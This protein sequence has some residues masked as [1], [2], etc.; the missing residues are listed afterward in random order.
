M[1][2]MITA[3]N[4]AAGGAAI[5]DPL[6]QAHIAY[7]ES[8]HDILLFSGPTKS[9]DGSRST[10]V[11]FILNVASK[12]EAVAFLEDEPY[13][14]AGLRANITLTRVKQSHWNPQVLPVKPQH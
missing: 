3:V 10:G 5:K 9:D 8:R 12:D 2:W 7:L 1:L 6:R 14:R 11:V 13:T 4:K